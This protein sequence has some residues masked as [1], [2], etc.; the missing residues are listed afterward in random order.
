M[1][2]FVLID[3]RH[4]DET[5]ATIELLESIDDDLDKVT[6]TT[7]KKQKYLKKIF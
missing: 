6:T 3:E 5:P 2:I 4:A 1:T 7:I